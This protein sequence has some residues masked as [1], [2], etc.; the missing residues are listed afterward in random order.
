VLVHRAVRSNE[1]LLNFLYRLRRSDR[2]QR[3]IWVLLGCT[4]TQQQFLAT[5]ATDPQP[6]QLIRFGWQYW[7]LLI[8]V[9]F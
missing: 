9:N 4:H 7:R 2:K 1:R 6:D 8:V 5:L 3:Q